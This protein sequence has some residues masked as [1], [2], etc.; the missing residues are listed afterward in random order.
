MAPPGRLVQFHCKGSS[1]KK[2]YA[3]VQ[4]VSELLH[5][6]LGTYLSP[7]SSDT[8]NPL[9]IPWK[10]NSDLALVAKFLE[11]SPA[12][13]VAYNDVDDTK[14]SVSLGSLVI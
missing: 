6:E 4:T 3:K 14:S 10:L 5:R 12:L 8:F 7:L 13:S 11:L 2:K 1:H 9:L